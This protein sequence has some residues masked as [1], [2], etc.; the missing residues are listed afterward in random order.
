MPEHENVLRDRFARLSAELEDLTRPG[1]R[2]SEVQRTRLI[3]ADAEQERTL[4]EIQTR[5]RSAGTPLPVIKPEGDYMN[6]ETRTSSD[7]HVTISYEPLTYERHAP[8]S[9]VQDLVRSKL[10]QDA[11]AGERL[12][13]HRE[14]MDVEL[15]A[16][17]RTDTTSVGE[18][19][20]P[21]WLVDEYGKALRPGRV[22]ANLCTNLPLPGGTDSINIP[23]LAA[24]TGQ[25]TTTAPQTADNATLSNQDMISNTVNAPVRTIGGY[26]DVALQ[27]VE[28]SPVGGGFDQVVFADLSADIDKQLDQQIIAGT[29][30]SGQL[31]GILGLTGIT[32]LT[33]T[34]ATPTFAT[35][36]PVLIQ[37]KSNIEKTRFANCEA[38]ALHPSRWNWL[39]SSLDSSNRPVVEPTGAGPYNPIAIST[40]TNAQ[41]AVGTIGGLPVYSSASI[42]TNLG[43][44]TNEDRIIAGKFSDALLYEGDLRVSVHPDALASSMGLRL[45]A[46]KY[47]AFAP[48]RYPKAFAIATGTGQVVTTVLANF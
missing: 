13:R 27:V 39:L 10:L 42:P 18:F 1:R 11:G 38:F 12:Q 25:G 15:R 34:Q 19:V 14:E 20:P 46:Y 9:Y 44:G 4:V 32:S 47:V 7:G 40:T 22:L 24:G 31:Q 33:Y 37:Q 17:S 5:T 35:Q 23:T 45:R 6:H 43:G 29:A 30:S 2:L 3:E 41:G 48:G 8:Y 26:V 36:Y 21:L 16:M 28:Q